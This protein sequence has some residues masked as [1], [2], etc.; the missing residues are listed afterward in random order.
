MQRVDYDAVAP[1]FNQRYARNRYEGARDALR[2]FA[3]E[4]A[5]ADVV[6]IGSGTGH[7]L[8]ELADCARS[9]VGIEPSWGMLQIARADAPTALIVQARAEEIPLA[10]ASIDRMICVNAFHHFGD[11]RA[12]VSEA[13]RVLRPGGGI[14]IIGIDPHTGLD[15]WWVYDYFPSALGADCARYPSTETIREL[16]DEAGFSELTSSVVQYA[17]T[18]RPF[19]VMLEH[20]HVDRHATSQLMVISDA[21]YD[22]GIRRM[23]AEQ[24]VM[25]SD[26]RV[27]ATIGRLRAPI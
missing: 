23:K 20:G 3:R 13:R 24:P 22:A 15:R 2:A 11:R 19:A 17:P 8:A 27:F 9:I 25:R 14:M 1:T 6:E 26:L 16:L 18:E 5:H 21:E 10:S 4:V 7:W 12:F